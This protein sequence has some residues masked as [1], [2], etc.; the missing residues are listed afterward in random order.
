MQKLPA[1]NT[2]T[3]RNASQVPGSVACYLNSPL[4]VMDSEAG[5]KTPDNNL[6]GTLTPAGGQDLRVPAVNANPSFPGRLNRLLGNDAERLD[7]RRDCQ[8]SERRESA[9][10][11]ALKGGVSSRQEI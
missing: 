5:L 7:I 2:Y 9:F 3:P 11:P 10:L 8:L 1:R 4:G 6:D